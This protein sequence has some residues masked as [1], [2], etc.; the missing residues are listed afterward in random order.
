MP[1]RSGYRSAVTRSA[2]AK[3]AK[4][5]NHSDIS[6]SLESTVCERRA[7]DYR[8]RGDVAALA[9]KLQNRHAIDA[10]P[11]PPAESVPDRA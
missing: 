2:A 7:L 8:T 1:R 11:A 4:A 3:A 5:D 6:P 9:R 10:G